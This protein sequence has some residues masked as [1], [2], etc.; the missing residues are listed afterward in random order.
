M[1]YKLV[2]RMVESSADVDPNKKWDSSFVGVIPVHLYP[3]LAFRDMR[4][5]M[6]P[7]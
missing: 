6:L 4:K 1:N 2:N 3:E 7:Q 5:A